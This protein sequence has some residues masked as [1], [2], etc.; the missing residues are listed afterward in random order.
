MRAGLRVGLAF[1]ALTQWAIGAWQLLLP[2]SF[3]DNGPTPG[4]AWVALVPPYSEHLM[5][6]VGALNLGLAVVLTVAAATLNPLMTRTA[7]VAY[8]VFSIPHLIF[9]ALHLEHFTRSEAV[10]QTVALAIGV[11]LPLG[12]LAAAARLHPWSDQPS[13]DERQRHETPA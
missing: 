13:P 5:R 10:A 12:L 9:H 11:A 2:R 7:L 4:S 8:L 3:Y 1:L 6:D